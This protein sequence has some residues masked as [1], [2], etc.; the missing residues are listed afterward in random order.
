MLWE[1]HLASGDG[2]AKAPRY[3]AISSNSGERT[4]KRNKITD[5]LLDEGMVC[6]IHAGTEGIE[7]LAI[8]VIS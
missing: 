7:T 4:D 5:H 8:A 6:G 3:Y 1:P 2:P